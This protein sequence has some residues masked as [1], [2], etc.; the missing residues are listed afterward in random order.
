MKKQM[1]NRVLGLLLLM[2]CATWAQAQTTSRL[3]TLPSGELSLVQEVI[4]ASTSTDNK[5]L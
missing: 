1:K 4:I 2:L 3:D 5:H